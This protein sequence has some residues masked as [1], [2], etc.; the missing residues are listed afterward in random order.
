MPMPVPTSTCSPSSAHDNTPATP[1]IRQNSI[2][3]AA[4]PCRLMARTYS[5]TVRV[6][7]TSTTAATAATACAPLWITNGESAASAS[8]GTRATA[9]C[10]VLAAR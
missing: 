6:A 2:A 5:D 7:F 8:V 4:A 9:F 10:T 1:G 3:T